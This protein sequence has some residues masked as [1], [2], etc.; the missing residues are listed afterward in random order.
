MIRDVSVARREGRRPRCRCVVPARSYWISASLFPAS[1]SNG[2]PYEISLNLLRPFV[3]D[4]IN[5]VAADV[6]GCPLA[7]YSHVI[8]LPASFRRRPRKG[9]GRAALAPSRHAPWCPP[10]LAAVAVFCSFAPHPYVIVTPAPLF[11]VVSFTPYSHVAAAPGSFLVIPVSLTPNPHVVL[12]PLPHATNI[13][14]VPLTPHPHIVLAPLPHTFP[15][16]DGSF[17]PQP[18]GIRVPRPPRLIRHVVAPLPPHSHVVGSPL[19]LQGL[20]VVGGCQ[21][22]R[23]ALP[24]N[25]HTPAGRPPFT[26]IHR[27]VT[28]PLSPDAHVAVPL[29]FVGVSYSFGVDQLRRD[30]AGEGLA[31]FRGVR[32]GRS[33]THGSCQTQDDGIERRH[34]H[35]ACGESLQCRRWFVLFVSVFVSLSRSV[36]NVLKRRNCT[37]NTRVDK[38]PTGPTQTYK[39]YTNIIGPTQTL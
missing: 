11:I 6:I 5:A 21:L 28:R 33:Q 24:P 9:E 20:L 36:P 35:H 27:P 34:M 23:G 18:H 14:A 30:A 1:R 12:A 15:V 38:Q 25:P 2:S 13:I 10:S 4:V 37:M 17:P 26:L 19:P 7:P 39:T 22:V 29:P 16:V 8:G 31:G 3:D 32:L